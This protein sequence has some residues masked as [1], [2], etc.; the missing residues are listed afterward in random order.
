MLLAGVI[1]KSK[2]KLPLDEK[3]QGIFKDKKSK[4]K[5]TKG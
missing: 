4:T 1:K 2:K 3:R 5:K